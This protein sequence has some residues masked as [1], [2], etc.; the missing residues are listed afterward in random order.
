M[1]P[2]LLVN[3]QLLERGLRQAA[4]EVL[5]RLHFQEADIVNHEF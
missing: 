1:P 4:K 3:P 5:H 2:E